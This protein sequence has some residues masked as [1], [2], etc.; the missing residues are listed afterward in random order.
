MNIG[1]HI[2]L[3]S[4]LI[5]FSSLTATGQDNLP[6]KT[7][8]VC[9]IELTGAG[10]AANFRFNYI[11]Q[12]FTDQSGSVEKVTQLAE[13]KPKMV[14]DD[15]LVECMHT[16]QLAPSTQ[17]AASFSIGTTGG[18]NYIQIV[19]PKRESLKLLLPDF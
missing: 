10:R 17:Y 4:L 7:I 3:T 18:P 12:I 14:R 2:L 1:Q 11:Y 9:R 8:T 15:K 6:K 13:R 16:W 5:G 19:E